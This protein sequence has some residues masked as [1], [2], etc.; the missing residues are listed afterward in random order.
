[1]TTPG[2]SK[3]PK[4]TLFLDNNAI[5]Y[6]FAGFTGFTADEIKRVRERLDARFGKGEV[7][8]LLTQPL[9]WEMAG[10][11]PRPHY[12]DMLDFGWRLS[13]ERVLSLG[14]DRRPAELLRGRKLTDDER[15]IDDRSKVVAFQAA[16]RDR[17]KA[18]EMS[19]SAVKVVE[20]AKLLAAK[21]KAESEARL[22]A[23][24]SQWRQ[25]LETERTARE[26]VIT[27]AAL[28]EM[29]ETARTHGFQLDTWPDPKALPTFWYNEARLFLTLELLIIQDGSPTSRKQ[30]NLSDWLHFE[31]CAY[32]DVLVTEDGRF[33]KLAAATN[34]PLRVTSFTDWARGML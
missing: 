27:D 22:S 2:P 25:K 12:S 10:A 23:Q 9:L 32:A 11:F 24:D 31:D 18:Q 16:L 21:Q 14:A 20:Q 15:Y 8:L 13:R 19:E 17:A 4:E 1:M 6:L 5:D 33:A 34:L 26:K 30:P 3:P 29:K 28:W 7:E